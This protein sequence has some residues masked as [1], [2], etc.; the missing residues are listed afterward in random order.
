MKSVLYLALGLS[1]FLAACGDDSSTSVADDPVSSSVE[2]SSSKNHHSSSSEKSGFDEKSSSSKEVLVSSSS[3]DKLSSSVE[4]TAESSSS[5]EELPSS[6]E[7]KPFDGTLTDSRDGHVYKAVKIGD[8]I[9]MAENLNY[10]TD[11]SGC[12][13]K[14]DSNCVKYGQLYMWSDAMDSAA[15]WSTN[16]RGCGNNKMCVPYGTVRGICPSGWHLPSKEEFETLF[17][18]VG[19]SITAAK[20]LKSTS[21]WN[22]NAGNGT[23]DYGFS[24]LPAG[25]GRNKGSMML[26]SDW[27]YDL[28]GEYASFWTTADLNSNSAYNAYT[29]SIDGIFHVNWTAKISGHSVRCVMD[30]SSG[31][32]PQSSSSALLDWN[33]PKESYL[34]SDVAYDSIT[35]SRDSKVYKTVQIGNQVWMAENLNYADSSKTPSLKGNSWCFDYDDKKCGVAGR[36]YTWSALIDSVKLAADAENPRECGYSKKCD[37]T[38]NVQ[39]IC[40]AGWHVPA[41]AEFDTLIA[42]VGGSKAA[43]TSLKS[44]IGWTPEGKGTDD[45]GFSAMPVGYRYSTGAFGD[46]GSH[47]FFWS[48]TENERN[49]FDA[50]YL[51]FQ[52]N[53][54]QAFTMAG[55]K[56]LAIPVR[57]VKD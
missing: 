51:Y 55:E 46:D 54:D 10:K 2:S 24:M 56:Y 17:S 30:D 20:K 6:S 48:L 21:G 18:A 9:W 1:A 16:G 26:F 3:T 23:D 40:P 13:N 44:R 43:S 57:C 7:S 28:E 31:E 11:K 38:G 14:L 4:S 32:A 34:N 29:S 35:D 52:S 42:Y 5:S 27:D 41:K 47:A 33:L 19:D 53:V 25:F 50:N 36:F 8:Q 22:A 12:Y 37:L 45:F 15:T 39:G 49:T